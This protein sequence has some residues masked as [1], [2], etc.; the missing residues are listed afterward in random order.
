MKQNNIN[1]YTAIRLLLMIV[2]VLSGQVLLAQDPGG[3]PGI[4]PVDGGLVFLLAAGVSYGAKK[5]Y[6]F[7][8]GMKQS[9]EEKE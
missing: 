7:R 8:K 9:N 4:I 5:A 1:F 2:L 6:D 3:D